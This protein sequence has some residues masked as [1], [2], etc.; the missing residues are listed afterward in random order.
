MTEQQIQTLLS[1]ALEELFEIDP[2][3]ITL[4]TNLY[5]DLEIDSIDAIDL[6]DYIKRKTGHKLQA[7]D[8]RSVR[9]VSDVIQAIL[10]IQ[11][12]Q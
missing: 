8:F 10:K 4:E 11:N 7:D 9:T 2:A 1:E 3:D 12:A 5:E 6:I